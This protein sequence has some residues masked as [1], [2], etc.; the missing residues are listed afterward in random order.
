MFCKSVSCSR[1]SKFHSVRQGLHEPPVFADIYKS[2][3]K[4]RPLYEFRL[5]FKRYRVKAAGNSLAPIF[6]LG[7]RGVSLN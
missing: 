7:Q 4:E 1:N 5:C 2:I 3:Q 6:A